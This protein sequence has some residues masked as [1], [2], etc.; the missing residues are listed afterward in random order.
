MSSTLI[1]A[2]TNTS[3]TD[4]QGNINDAL[5][6]VDIHSIDG[7]YIDFGNDRNRI[8][9]AYQ[10]VKGGESTSSRFDV[11]T[12]GDSDMTK[13]ATNLTD[14]ISQKQGTAD[15]MRPINIAAQFGSDKHRA[16][17]ALTSG[18]ESIVPVNVIYEVIPFKNSNIDD[19]VSTVNNWIAENPEYTVI[20]QS[21]YYGNGKNRM[22][23]LYS[24]V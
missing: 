1:I 10:P 24:H 2:K 12:E 18:G 16:V 20:D 17:V 15:K 14:E 6:S 23:L 7:L 8:A 4:V 11:V 3:I 13:V 19:L 22:M 9:V 21:Y 5:S